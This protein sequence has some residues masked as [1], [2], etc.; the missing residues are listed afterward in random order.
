VKKYFEVSSS[1]EAGASKSRSR[2]NKRPNHHIKGLNLTEAGWI[3]LMAY[4]PPAI[5]AACEAMRSHKG[6]ILQ[7]FTFFSRLCFNYCKANKLQPDWGL[8]FNELRSKGYDKDAIGVDWE[9]PY[10]YYTQEE[11]DAMGPER[12]KTSS[13]FYPK[14]KT[15]EPPLYPKA[16]PP[17]K[18]L[19]DRWEE[20][21][22]AKKNLEL[23]A[24]TGIPGLDDIFADILRSNILYE[25]TM[26]LITTT[27]DQI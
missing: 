24:K 8:C 18:R 17:Q 4:P 14:T 10:L 22:K 15:Q 21:E 6:D 13:A 1:N 20:S 12:P 19:F 2:D 11:V 7:P 3:K 23:M 9:N 26:D 27:N 25:N 16:I 5:Q